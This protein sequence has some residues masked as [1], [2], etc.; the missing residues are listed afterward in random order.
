MQR[1]DLAYAH[2]VVEMD[3]AEFVAR[4]LKQDGGHHAQVRDMKW[5]YL[6][7]CPPT[8]GWATAALSLEQ[9]RRAYYSDSTFCSRIFV[10]CHG[11]PFNDLGKIVRECMHAWSGLRLS[12]T[13]FRKFIDSSL[14]EGANAKK[15][16]LTAI[17]LTLQR[18]L[19]V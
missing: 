19:M 5:N 13:N 14:S 6:W 16:T 12:M 3:A 9:L 18:S 7:R 4:K 17:A 11:R 1:A 10:D 15:K 2:E 8:A